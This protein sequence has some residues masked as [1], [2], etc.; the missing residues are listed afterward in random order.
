MCFHF[1]M[2][3]ALFC[4]IKIKHCERQFLSSV[5]QLFFSATLFEKYRNTLI[6]I[7]DK[8]LLLAF[9][10]PSKDICHRYK[11]RYQIYKCMY[12]QQMILIFL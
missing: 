4:H 12:V 1:L 3:N 11:K 8:R 2:T 9:Q 5:W 10:F 7:S 6:F